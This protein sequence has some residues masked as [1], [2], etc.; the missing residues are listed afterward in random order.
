MF[1]IA[2]YGTLKLS[3][4]LLYRRIFVGRMFQRVSLAMVVLVALWVTAFFFGTLFQCG[5]RPEWF[6]QS[7]AAVKEH[8]FHYKY[9]QLG[10]ASSDVATD[11]MVLAL[12]VPPIWKLHMS[13]VQ[14]ISLTFTFL[15]GLV[16]VERTLPQLVL[17]ESTAN[18]DLGLPR[19]ALQ[20]SSS[21]LKIFMV[22]PTVQVLSWNC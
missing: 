14:K 8:C 10:H 1:G 17:L 16:L 4:L 22:V 13:M 9:I 19:L 6:W 21:L 11:L 7:S 5:R 3:V 12:P 15:L 18:A 20:D 2:T